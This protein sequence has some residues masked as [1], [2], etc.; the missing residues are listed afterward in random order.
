MGYRGGDC[1][2]K[3]SF[4]FYVSMMTDEVSMAVLNDVIV[5]GRDGS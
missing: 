4:Q 5:S 3:G 2:V 1:S